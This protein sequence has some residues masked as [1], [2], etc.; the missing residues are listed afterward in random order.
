[1]INNV[2]VSLYGVY[3]TGDPSC[4]NSL[5]ASLPLS[6]NPNLSNFVASPILG[7]GSVPSKISCVILI[8]A[9]SIQVGWQASAAYPGADNLCSAGGTA[10]INPCLSTSSVV[11]PATILADAKALGL[12]LATS[13]SATP[14]GTEIVPVFMSVNSSCTGNSN[15]DKT[16]SGC[17]ALG[18]STSSPSQSP[19]TS[20][21]T[22]SGARIPLT[23]PNGR[24]IFAVD[25]DQVV[26]GIGATCAVTSLPVFSIHQ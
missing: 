26:G 3:M 12:T 1:M 14:S 7:A 13:C 18:K 5:I 25:P 8:L 22:S 4:Q 2:G 21:S 16:I 19:V 17:T 6:K 10:P 24:L 15:I 11:W 9:N 20:N 23:L